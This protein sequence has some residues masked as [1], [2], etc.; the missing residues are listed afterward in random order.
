MSNNSKSEESSTTGSKG[1]DQSASEQKKAPEFEDQESNE[2]KSENEK[3]DKSSTTS[4]PRLVVHFLI[5]CVVAGFVLLYILLI[6]LII[7]GLSTSVLVAIAFVTIL[8]TIPVYKY[9]RNIYFY[10]C[11][12]EKKPFKLYC[13][14]CNIKT[15]QQCIEL[16]K[17][18]RDDYVCM[19]CI[20]REMLNQRFG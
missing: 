1:K 15:W 10:W 4:L 18:G 8:V 5:A 12:N 19:A 17:S 9:F 6:K 14:K 20:S 11:I 7:D 13:S 3:E 16:N 2:N